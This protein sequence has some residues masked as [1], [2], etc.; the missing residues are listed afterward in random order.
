MR[1]SWL[2]REPYTVDDPEPE[3]EPAVPEGKSAEQEDEPAVQED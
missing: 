1:G 3:D 2:Q